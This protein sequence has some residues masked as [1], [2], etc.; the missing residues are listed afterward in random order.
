M[1]KSVLGTLSN[2]KHTVGKKVTAADTIS[3][4]DVL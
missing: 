3:H 4:Q 2:T 1:E